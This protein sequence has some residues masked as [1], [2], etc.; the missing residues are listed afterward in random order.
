MATTLHASNPQ[1]GPVTRAIAAMRNDEPVP[2]R[3][4]FLRG[5]LSLPLIGGGVTLIGSPSAVAE[6][7]TLPLM[8][9][10][11]AFLAREHGHAHDELLG[12]LSPEERY[13]SG[14]YSPLSAPIAPLADKML[15]HW[16]MDARADAMVT[17][18][19]PSTRAALVLST[20]GADWREGGR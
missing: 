17:A 12:M 13:Y 6:P 5:L 10:Y 8:R 14:Y 16:P 11:V 20:I 3:R 7:L 9:R 18:A 19:P 2:P 15:S 4:G 1:T